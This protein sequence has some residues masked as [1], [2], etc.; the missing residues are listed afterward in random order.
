MSSSSPAAALRLTDT[1]R[2][3]LDAHVES[4]TRQVRE[5]LAQAAPESPIAA[6]ALLYTEDDDTPLIEY[7][8]A[9]TS[10][11]LSA[12][13]DEDHEAGL[14]LLWSPTEWDIEDVAQEAFENGGNAAEAVGEDLRAVG[15]ASAKALALREVA[16]RLT[17]SAQD[18]TPG[19]DEHFVVWSAPAVPDE[20]EANESFVA[21]F[22]R[23]ATPSV[24][25]TYRERD[26][27]REPDVDIRRPRRAWD[28]VLPWTETGPRTEVEAD[29]QRLIDGIGGAQ[30]ILEDR[31]KGRWWAAV[32]VEVPPS[33]DPEELLTRAIVLCPRKSRE[34]A[35]D[36]ASSLSEDERMEAIWNPD[37]WAGTGAHRGGRVEL[38]HWGGFQDWERRTFHLLR[39]AGIE[40][41]HEWFALEACRRL[42][43]ETIENVGP[44]F[45][46]IPLV[47][48]TVADRLDALRTVAPASTL[49]ALA[50]H[51]LLT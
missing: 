48:T 39:D 51:G 27:L 36:R 23:A 11:F 25:R 35:L 40:D 33:R 24:L 18:S 1:A 38:D 9:C 8:Y 3:R 7:T 44:N 32:A 13:F 21:A 28:P 15:V 16:W 5:G 49:A 22:R 41:P 45:V 17:R 2:G 10:G 12:A 6:V 30:H 46:A 14:R 4:L 47:G 34:Q 37:T 19:L 31:R 26:W 50:E 29:A 42:N 43:H 20:T